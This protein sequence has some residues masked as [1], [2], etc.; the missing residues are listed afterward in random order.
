MEKYKKGDYIAVMTNQPDIHFIEMGDKINHL[1][2][3]VLFL[4]VIDSWSSAES[5][6]IDMI[7]HGFVNPIHKILS[8]RTKNKT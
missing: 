3:P 2:E 6:R 5:K 7:K 8:F 1:V 4:A